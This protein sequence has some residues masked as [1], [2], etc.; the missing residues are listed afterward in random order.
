MKKSKSLL[1]LPLALC[2]LFSCGKP[3]NV[4]QEEADMAKAL[5]SAMKKGQEAYNGV[6]FETRFA[7]KFHISYQSE[8]ENVQTSYSRDYDAEG[9]ITMAYILNLQEGESFNLGKLYNE[10]SAYFNGAQKEISNITHHITPKAGSNESSR[11]LTEDYSYHHFFG[12]QFDEDE[13]LAKANDTL[14]DRIDPSANRNDTF[15]GKITKEAVD[16]YQ[17]E[18]LEASL[19]RIL[20]LSTW[21]EVSSCRNAISMYF[22]NLPLATLDDATSFIRGNGVSFTREGGSLK[23]TFSLMGSQIFRYVL[24]SAPSVEKPIRCT[25]TIDESKALPT[26]YEYDFKDVYAAML[27]QKK[28][29]M[30]YFQSSMDSFVIRGKKLDMP[31]EELKLEGNFTEYAPE[32]ASDFMTQ[33]QEHVIPRPAKR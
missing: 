12:I 5:A 29:S 16:G 14:E 22:K 4:S 26:Q 18:A 15:L 23:A 10:G 25:V 6:A 28:E 17:T 30:K 8:N 21:S 19:G 31:A 32:Q 2:A 24:S 9:S 13:L 1:C 33:V 3:S 7:Q 27:E 11:V 20:Y